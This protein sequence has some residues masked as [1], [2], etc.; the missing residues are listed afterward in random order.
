MGQGSEALPRAAAIRTFLIAD[1]RG[2]TRFTA[3]HGDEAASRLAG[4]FAEIAAG[5]VEAWGGNLVELRGDEA[6][7][8][9][10]SPR[11]ALRCAVELQSAFADESARDT[12][13]PLGVGVG[14]DAGEAVPVGDGYR[15]AA[16][17][18]AARLCGAA[19]PGEILASQGLLHLA[20]PVPGLAFDPPEPATFKGYD[21]E[22]QLIRVHSRGVEPRPMGPAGGATVAGGAPLPTEARGLPPELDPII[23]LVGRDPELQWLRWHWRR[24]TAGHG[25]TVVI[26]GRPGI[27]KTR[28]CAELAV[29]AHGEGAA[30][31][32]RPAGGRADGR[33]LDLASPAGAAVLE[34]VDDLDA[35]GAEAA[36]ATIDRAAEVDGR[37]HLLVVTHRLESPPALVAL[38]ERL[39][40]PEQR[41][42]LEPLDRSAVRAITALYAGRPAD[43]APLAD[44]VAESDGV[45]AAVHKVA[46]RWARG[47][48]S[49]RLGASADRTATERHGLQAAEAALVADMADLELVR[50]RER[51]YVERPDGPDAT[52]PPRAVCP[53]K[54]L[55]EFEAADADHYF[56][57][58][59]L[60][61]EMVARFV[62]ARL[63]GLVGDSGSGKSSALRA[64]LLPALAGGM[65]PS[66]DTWPQVLLR[67]GEHPLAELGRA[68]A[69]AFP[70]G[71]VA[72]DDPAAALDRALA[73]LG[74]GRRLVVVVDQFEEVFNAARDEV[75][76][77]AFIDLLTRERPGL[78]VIVSIRADYYGRCA[79][80]PALARLLG[81]DQVLVGP[82][83]GTEVAAVIEHPAQR[84]GLRIEPALTEALVSDAGRE[85]GVLPLL[86]TTLLELWGMRE[87]S[88][89]TL[90][91]YRASGGLH[92]AIAR[93]AEATFAELDPHRQQ[94]ARS[95]L[96]RLAGPG[97]GTE[98]VRRRVS[99][100]ELDA[101]RDPVMAEVLERL[102]SARLLTVG[103]GHVEVA[104]EAL[105]REWPRLQ[106]WLEEDAAGRQVR[107]H[108][109]G[110]VRDWE[111]RGREPGDLY[112]GA[113]LS[114]ALE[115]AGE[116]GVEL[117]ASEREF[118]EASRSAAE[119]EVERQRRTNRRLRGLLAG[120]AALL[121]VAVGAGGL[122]ALQAQRAED[123]TRNAESQAAAA[124]AQRLV[125][126]QEG[127][128]ARSRELLASALS[129]T[130]EDPSLGKALAA[131]AV[132][133]A[134][135]PTIQSAKILHEVLAADPVI[136]RYRR[137]TDKDVG[138]IWTDLDPAGEMLVSSGGVL[139]G[140]AATHLEVVDARTGAV[141]WSYDVEGDARIGPSFFSR[142]GTTV[143][144]GALWDN[145]DAPPSA[146][147]LGV[148]IWD[149]RSG[150]LVRR[151]DL[152]RCGALVTSVTADRLLVRT[153]PAGPSANGG[154]DWYD[155]GDPAV[156]IVDLA[157]GESRVIQPRAF[158][159]FGGTLSA[160]GRYAAFDV[161]SGSRAL[162]VVVEVATGKRVFELDPDTVQTFQY[163]RY[164][165]LL[166][167]DGSLLLFGDRPILVYD[168]A[169]GATEPITELPSPGGEG[170]YAAFDSSG[171]IVY[172]T[173]RDGTLRAWDVRSTQQLA[174]WP[175]AGNGRVALAEDGHTVL[176]GSLISDGAS[177]LDIGP[178][179]ELGGVATCPGFVPANSLVVGSGRAA[180]LTVCDDPARGS[181]VQLV[182]L[183]GPTLVAS[184]S[185]WGAQKMAI[186]PDGTRFAV[187]EQT[188]PRAYGP[189]RTIDI[190]TGSVAVTLQG[191]CAWDERFEQDANPG[192]RPFPDPPFEMWS[193]DIRWSPDGAMIAIADGGKVGLWD[194]RDGRL[195][196]T[197][198]LP[199]GEGVQ[200]ILFTPDSQGIL[201]MESGT[202]RL[203]LLSTET[204]AAVR[205]G[206]LDPDVF[207]VRQLRLIGH[208]PDG[209]TILAV[210][211]DSGDGGAATFAIDATSLRIRRTLAD[212]HLGSPKGYALSPDRS[213][214][215][216]GASDGTLKVWGSATG[217]L[218]QQLSIGQR[219]VQGVAFVDD[220]TLAVV[221]REGGLLVMTIDPAEL[222]D[223]L[224]R[225]LTRGF[226]ATECATYG[227]DRCPTLDEL[228]SAPPG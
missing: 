114:T 65:L 41:R 207:G 89:L 222:Q 221:P 79:A 214:F 93:L 223:V 154:C 9:F 74:S 168:V 175:S 199:D 188:G 208:G 204:L 180:F 84:V 35:A 202:G 106:G 186:S 45:P 102:S 219:Q 92:G 113:R 129:V 48:A 176:V 183:D 15:G 77:S 227:L 5:G 71:E 117:N 17:N 184:L 224:R 166:S 50:D 165:R 178:R 26:S 143:I 136:A 53:Y 2:Y 82:L 120:A 43:D 160:D 70:E 141:F 23:P 4:H 38:A 189:V 134:D 6:L 68:L 24:A 111:R 211:D 67:P 14:L 54:G 3:Q 51:R 164:A 137:P 119:L 81:S 172:T 159:N 96:L 73:S 131:E 63:L 85:P 182:D 97:E 147:S 80:Y 16:L 144:A 125:A 181:E 216:T 40:P 99:L 103:D 197:H 210:G 126:E 7:A 94:L 150:E 127:V 135:E 213:L 104:H 42:T 218:Q 174:A 116:H 118:L 18:L 158:L 201:V 91:S 139:G 110:A 10:E 28:L 95:L 225:S 52:V 138:A 167:P 187:Q 179:G 11:Q 21:G 76:P 56:G 212:A 8:V 203:V 88:R 196:R 58:E 157:T 195:L 151:L 149:A 123:E 133:L 170:F 192:C 36:Q 64:G 55:A 105:L 205:T 19:G 78:K 177:L 217:E 20:G 198:E 87:G 162:S 130:D 112:R 194:G 171:E 132:R 145:P 163:N 156:A 220:H 215:A 228:R 226:T 25:R 169:G 47:A 128:R 59:R 57:R 29:L 27:G 124:E 108:L 86:S 101:D 32:Y 49:R 155:Q 200:S 185:G 75:E 39:A 12:T 83:T 142:D 146:G 109:I 206:Q 161:P 98:L 148:L 61:A 140:D 62:G 173:A 30:V 72:G 37:R 209:G 190:G 31:V 100:D 153:L 122:A 152:G 90:A 46:S 66:S 1:I 22:V 191:L 115:W 34:V 193:A 60:I 121:L 13:M 69:R 107:L 33:T 44:I